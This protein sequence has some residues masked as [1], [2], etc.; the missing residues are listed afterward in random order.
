MLRKC[1]RWVVSR[2]IQKTIVLEL[3]RAR[4]PVHAEL[5]RNLLVRPCPLPDRYSKLN[6]LE[7]QE[8]G[9]QLA[10]GKRGLRQAGTDCGSDVGR[11][12][13]LGHFP[14]R[15]VRK[16][17]LEHLGHCAV[18]LAMPSPPLNRALPLS[19]VPHTLY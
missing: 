16:R 19:K 1:L 8:P 4:K 13:T 2:Q 7:I 10:C 6:R 15:A 11:G 18:H 12:R 14:D 9:R 17:D 5:K 3:S